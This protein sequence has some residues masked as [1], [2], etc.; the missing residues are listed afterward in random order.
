MSDFIN[1]HRSNH[2][3]PSTAR[4]WLDV[5]RAA[6]RSPAK[7]GAELG[8][9]KAVTC[10]NSVV[11]Q[12]EHRWCKPR[13]LTVIAGRALA[14]AA[15]CAFGPLI[16]AESPKLSFPVKCEIGLNC[17]IQNYFDRVSGPGFRDYACGFLSYDGHDGT[18]I[19]VPNLAVMR[20]GINVVAAAPGQ[21]RAIRDAMPD[22]NVR[23][24]GVDAVRGRE[25]GNAVA[26]RHGA[27]WE[28]QY[29]HLMRGSIRVRAGDVVEA[30]EVLGLIGLSGN[31]EFPHLH[32][33]VRYRGEP[34]DP[35]V[36]LARPS[37]C[38]AGPGQ[39]WEEAALEAL[40]Y[41]PTGLLQAGF[42]T[43][44]PDRESVEN[45]R[46]LS[47]PVSAE[48]EA[49]LFWVEIFGAQQGDREFI[50]LRA[51]DG[52]VVAEKEATLAGNKARW[53]SY[54]GRRR[55]EPWPPGTYT[56]LYRLTRAEVDVD[57]TVIEVQRSIEVKAA[58]S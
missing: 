37:D 17:S 46:A 51:P 36:G 49:L 18:D 15:F 45:G 2:F 38:G 24:T 12:N 54:V 47:S 53:L 29:S 14:M 27:D 16:A 35:F 19:R 48:A 56:A 58:P 8:A 52:T 26:L 31:T 40:R 55:D 21:V 20:R 57:Q 5:C 34:V 32:F 10:G 9:G 44:V 41:T 22:V 25:A 7:K 30:G 11:A 33:E 4:G 3:V 23:D 6:I 39:L 50:R 28:T 42:A 13:K 1:R 43:S